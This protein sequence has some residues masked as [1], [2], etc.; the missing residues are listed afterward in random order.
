MKWCV[1]VFLLV[2]L[3]AGA[4]LHAQQSDTNSVENIK[5]KAE[6]GDAIAQHNL[7][8]RYFYGKGVPEMLRCSLPFRCHS[9]NR[10][11]ATQ[12]RRAVF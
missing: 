8:L 7:A 2:V 6:S 4:Q 11:E 9:A 10:L 5:A 12:N 1:A 3:C